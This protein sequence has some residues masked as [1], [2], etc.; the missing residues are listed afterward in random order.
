MTVCLAVHDKEA[1]DEKFDEFF[2]LIILGST[3]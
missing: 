3:G 1:G 2:K